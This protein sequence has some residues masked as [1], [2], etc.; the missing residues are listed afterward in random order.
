MNRL[1]DTDDNEVPKAFQKN[2]SEEPRRMKNGNNKRNNRSKKKKG[3][4]TYSF[5]FDII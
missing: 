2:R 3:L 5:N 4:K 1:Y